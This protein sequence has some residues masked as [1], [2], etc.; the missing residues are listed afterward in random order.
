[1][2]RKKCRSNEILEGIRYDFS[3]NLNPFGTPESIRESVYESGSITSY[4]D[5]ECSQLRARLSDRY[6]IPADNIVCCNGVSEII[7]RI[8]AACGFKRVLMSVPS[9]T[10]YGNAFEDNGIEVEYLYTSPDNDFVLNGEYL[11]YGDDYDAVFTADPVNLS[12]AVMSSG[13]LKRIS[14]WCEK[15]DTVLVIDESGMDLVDQEIF[16]DYESSD[17]ENHIIVIRSF[18]KTFAMG[19]A[20][21]GFAMFSDRKMAS[22][23]AH[24]GFP[25]KVSGVAQ[26]AAEA[27]L[28]EQEFVE[29]SVRYIGAEREYMLESLREMGYRCFNS[30]ANYILFLGEKSLGA[31]LRGEGFLVYDCLDY[32]GLADLEGRRFYRIAVR[33]H[34]ENV[35]LMDTIGRCRDRARH[36]AGIMIQG[37]MSEVG[38][39]TI[40][41]SLC[42]IFEADGYSSALISI[43][44]HQKR[45]GQSGDRAAEAENSVKA[46]FDGLAEDHDIVVIDGGAGPAEY[47]PEGLNIDEMR[48]ASMIDL[49]VLLVGDYHRGGIFAQ[50]FGTLK[51]LHEEERVRV[52]GLV[53]NNSGILPEKKE[54]FSSLMSRICGCEVMGIVS[55][56]GNADEAFIIPEM[57]GGEG[58]DPVLPREVQ[59]PAPEG[60]SVELTFDAADNEE[61]V[62]SSEMIDGELLAYSWQAGA[63]GQQRPDYL[64]KILS[65]KASAKQRERIRNAEKDLARRMAEIEKQLKEFRTIKGFVHKKAEND[66]DVSA[67]GPVPVSSHNEETAE[68][69]GRKHFSIDDEIRK[70]IDIGKLY[71]IMGLASPDN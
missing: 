33:I 65:R 35:L 25:C 27:A 17:A 10:I 54:V 1:M 2:G 29:R 48:L 46:V 13:E 37:T 44:D 47:D 55:V 63:S 20:G 53:V 6:E 67:G 19:G 41:S 61:P 28:R 57:R 39:S 30:A 32:E 71:Q 5:S 40:A 49:P 15:T 9:F 43:R 70:S 34:R 68:V 4:P 22:D 64:K 51:L 38:K 62:R 11:A 60:A 24:Y 52:K 26:S 16:E 66:A 56:L 58:P 18:T 23:V 36:A 3:V 21:M 50:M 7:Y 59:Q 45:Y 14:E 31:E 8:C 12:G 42:R 69:S